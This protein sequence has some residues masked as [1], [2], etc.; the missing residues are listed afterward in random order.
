M[1]KAY[2]DSENYLSIL[3]PRHAMELYQVIDDSRESIGRWLSF[4]NK[5]DKV[6][7]SVIFIEKSLKRLSEN[8]GYWAGIWHN[9]HIVGSVGFL[10]IDWNARKTE[11]GYWLGEK[12][13]GKGFATKAVKHFID[14]AFNDLDLRKIEM[15]VATNNFKS[16][17]IP[18]RLGF[19]QEGIIRNYQYLNGAYQDRVIYGLLKDEWNKTGSC[20]DK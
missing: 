8:N 11:I 4:P 12:F 15:N 14:H 13:T 20:I 7:D 9:D 1:Y 3:E 17:A 2:I 10:Y 18:E 16:R 5:T 6:E 19:R